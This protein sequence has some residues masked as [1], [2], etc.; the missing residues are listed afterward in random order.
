[1]VGALGVFR[2]ATVD[3]FQAPDVVVSRL[4]TIHP[5]NL[6]GAG[7]RTACDPITIYGDGLGAGQ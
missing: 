2:Q 1:M 7:E 4:A 5:R 6:R 3:G